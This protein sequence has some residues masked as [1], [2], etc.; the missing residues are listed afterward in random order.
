MGYTE[1]MLVDVN[2]VKARLVARGNEVR[3]DSPT[4]GK[5]T[6]RIQFALAAQHGW[7]VECSD[8]TAA[9]LQGEKLSRDVFVTPPPEAQE[10]GKI[11]KLLKPVY[12]LDDACR[13][14][15]LKAAETLIEYGCNRSK[16]DSALFL[17]FKEGKVVGFIAMH[18]DDLIHAGDKS[19][20]KDVIEPL[21]K[22]FKFGSMSKDA[23]KYVGWHLQHEGG[24]VLV[25]QDDYIE[26][27]IFTVELASQ[28]RRNRSDPLS[29]EENEMFKSGVGKGRWL[30]DQT[31]PDCSYDELELSMMTK[32]A[33]VND[34]LK[35]NKMFLK[36]KQDSVKMKY[37]QLGAT[38]KLT[39]TVFSDASFANLPD[40]ESSGMGYLIFLSV[41]FT[42]GVS[43]PCS[44][45]S[46]TAC[47]VRRKVS[48]TCAAET[49]SLLAALEQAIVMRHQIT[50][51]L[52]KS[53]QFIKIEAFIDN[54]DAYE[55]IYSTKQILSG[56]LRIDIGAIKEM[57]DN[58][59]IESVSWIPAS[60][61]LA[62]CLTKRGASTK[63]LLETLNTGM[64]PANL[65]GG[66]DF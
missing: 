59:E 19:F 43:S 10:E 40:G 22:F 28:R 66:G 29:E 53:P 21:R 31:R 64:F 18:V 17:Y 62:D 57:V 7:K 65:N 12:G 26:E 51:I 42:A 16:Y 23:F 20:E 36:L 41:G 46:W 50:E 35:L 58:K 34:V 2:G 33:T 4:I 48:S 5:P 30:T 37:Q 8:V 45:L 54:K 55:A 9:F 32:K 47:K 56:R 60:H 49:L 14:F 27:K 3:T 38:E 61:Q 25:D 15:Y 24:S 39:L 1:K 63:T 13:N 44:L 11:W 6:L 52:N